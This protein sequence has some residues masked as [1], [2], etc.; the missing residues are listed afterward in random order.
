MPTATPPPR[1]SDSTRARGTAAE[2]RAARHYRLRGY[3]ILAANAWAGGYELDLVA[4]RG[5]RLVFCEVKDKASAR[6]GDPFEMVDEEKQRRIRAAAETWLSSRPDLAQ[7][8][9]R[10]EII[11][12]R[13]GHLDRLVDAF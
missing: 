13:S 11:A 7:L 10:F 2:R 8:E 3:R 5:R 12:V 4:R 9:V 6:F 1:R